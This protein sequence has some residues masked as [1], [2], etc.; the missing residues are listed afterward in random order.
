L[1]SYFIGNI[2]AKKYQNAFTCAEV[3][4]SRRWDVFD[5]RCINLLRS[6][7]SLKL[8]FVE[9]RSISVQFYTGTVSSISY[10]RSVKH[11]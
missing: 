6:A 9:Y 11:S 5:T 10:T 3:I 7:I 8:I 1:V 4:A 2:S